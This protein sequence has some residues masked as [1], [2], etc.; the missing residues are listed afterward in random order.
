RWVC[1]GTAV[2]RQLLANCCGAQRVSTAD[3]GN[4]GANEL[5][6][7]KIVHRLYRYITDEWSTNT[8]LASKAGQH[9]H[10]HTLHSKR[11]S[12]RNQRMKLQ[13]NLSIKIRIRP[14]PGLTTNTFAPSPS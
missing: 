11:T 10:L 12:S 4:N 8:W 5:L 1:A 6:C 3:E 7:D 9:A 2:A 13:C 14:I